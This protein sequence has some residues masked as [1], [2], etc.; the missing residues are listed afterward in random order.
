M[1]ISEK[2][3]VKDILNEYPESFD[4]FL[5]NGFKFE[6][7]KELIKAVGEKTMLKTVLKLRDIN[8]DLFLFDLEKRILSAMED[9]EFILGDY[10]EGDQLDFYGN[11]ICPL[12]FTFKDALEDIIKNKYEKSGELLKCYIET[13]REDK[14]VCDDSV[15]SYTIDNFPNVVFAKGFSEYLSKDFREKMMGRGYFGGDFY[16]NVTKEIED[17][18]II[19]PLGE[20]TIYSVM[21][22]VFL[23]DRNKLGDLP[24]PKTM[25]DLLNPIYKDNIGIFG[26]QKNEL[27]NAIFLYVNKEFGEEGLKKLAN[28]VKGAYH[29]SQMSK[30]A[31]SMSGEGAAI[32]LVSWF[33][34]KTCSKKRL[35]YIGLRMVQWYFLCIC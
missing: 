11:T 3:L 17:A 1:K 32:Y 34:A 14:D 6:S 19:D 24:V 12:K 31:G 27:S 13:G 20:Y 23:M 4:V 7:T 5:V 30:L 29:G 35:R 8:L 9:K 15:F 10:S 16:N 21:A 28:N 22:D 26:M 25:E 33:F 18:G 2:I